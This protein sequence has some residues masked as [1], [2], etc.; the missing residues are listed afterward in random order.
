LSELSPRP[1]E[2]IV[3]L[4]ADADRLRTVAALVLG[5]QSHADV[6]A[7]TGLSLPDVARAIARLVEG[8]LVFDEGG[9]FEVALDVIAQAAREGARRRPAEPPR[10]DVPPEVAKVLRAF[11]RDGRLV[12]IPTTRPKRLVVLDRL[13]QEFEPGRRYSEAMVNLVLGRWHA[14]TAS[15]RRHLVDEGFLDRADGQYWRSGGSVS[16]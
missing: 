9:R 12:S 3:G 7:A 16:V 5:A 2:A 14:D 11:V 8:G 1:P 13:A 15:L 10:G 4:L 6:A